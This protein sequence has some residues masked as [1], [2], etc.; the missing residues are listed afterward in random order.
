VSDA[1]RSRGTILTQR[2]RS[3]QRS[4]L[5]RFLSRF[6]PYLRTLGTL[7]DFLAAGVSFFAAYVFTIGLESAWIT[8]GII[9]KLTLFAFGSA[10]I[11]YFFS[12]NGGS[13]RYASLP[14]LTAIIKA[15]T[16]AV[17]GYVLVQ[18]LYSRGDGLPRTVPIVLWLFMIA[19]LAGPRI[20]F[21]IAK[22]SGGFGMLTG[23]SRPKP[24]ATHVLIYGVNDIAE[25]YIRAVRLRKGSDVFIAGLVDDDEE[26]RGRILQGRRVLGTS[27]DLQMVKELLQL[28]GLNITELVVADSS[29]SAQGL[30]LLVER[31]VS[32]GLKITRLPDILRTA[33]IRGNTHFDPKPLEVRDLLGRKEISLGSV[34]VTRLIEGRTIL[35]TGA[36]G[37]IGSELAR[38]IS[39]FNPKRFVLCDISEHFLYSI[40][41]ELTEK[42]PEIEFVARIA[43]V[44]DA[45]RVNSIFEEFRPDVVFHAAALK[46]VPL[47]EDNPLE[48][49]KTNLFGTKNCADAAL[50]HGTNVF[51]M[52]STDKAVNPTNVMG[53]TKRASEAYCQMLDLKSEHTRFKTVRFGNVLGSN[54]SVVPRFASQIAKGGPVTVTHPKIMR[55][56]MTIPEAVTLVL[57]SSAHGE[58]ASSERGKILVLNMGKPV[59]IAE[60]AQR[61]IQLA[62]LR[63]GIDIQIEYTGLRPG[64]KLYEELFDPSEVEAGSESDSYLV[65]SPRFVEQSVLEGALQDMETHASKDELRLVMN[66]LKRIVPEFRRNGEPS[67]HPPSNVIALPAKQGKQA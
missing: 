16:I 11:F 1:D 63:P 17:L 45:R 67:L 23:I 52:I 43:D 44:R 15:S 26:K 5:T 39:E 12:L 61:M 55:F 62:G 22:E 27:A 9:E 57:Q 54:G 34:E 49:V 18:F 2:G 36:G 60:L 20:V 40:D 42:H 59:L 21:R 47:V 8:P 37:S 19:S 10:V 14:D 28:K 65:V 30:T 24:G 13:W 31:A 58:H 32:A 50:S 35:L 46:H 48:A 7:H 3:K 29:L 38:Q 33:T 6:Q 53:A 25:A 64:E 66:L 56:F 51:V 41:M 4:Y